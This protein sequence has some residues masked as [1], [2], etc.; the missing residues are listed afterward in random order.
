MSDT[1]AGLLPAAG[2][3]HELRNPLVSIQTFSALLKEHGHESEF[4][5]EFGTI[6][7]RDVGRIASIVENIAAFAANHDVPFTAVKVEE[8]IKGA[9]EIVHPEL[10][11]TGVQLQ[12]SSR[13]PVPPV[14]GNFSQLLQ[15]LVNLF[16]NAIQ[17]LEGRPAGRITVTLTE[18]ARDR[19]TS[20]LCI[21]V[22]DNG[23]G[24]DPVLLS[25]VFEPFATTK[26]TGDER[27]KRGMGLGLAIVRRIVQYHQ[28]AIDVTSERGAGAT[29]H[30]YLP[31][32]TTTP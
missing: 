8:V 22:A 2:L 20:M 9:A 21:T 10:T 28:G 12:F 31:T 11:R 25:R 17:A 23:P 5:Q 16:Q 27:N 30:V 19:L 29:F 14:H 13:R 18:Q 3:A 6:M 32:V 24:I 1:P 7:Q 15:V 26:S 4:Q